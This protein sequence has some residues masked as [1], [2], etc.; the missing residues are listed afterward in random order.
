M[1]P[2]SCPWVS[3][4]TCWRWGE[5]VLRIP[6]WVWTG[7]QDIWR[8]MDC[9]TIRTFLNT[10]CR[11]PPSGLSA[12]SYLWKASPPSR[13]SFLSKRLPSPAQ[14]ALRGRVTH[15]SLR[16]PWSQRDPGHPS[17]PD[18][19]LC[20]VTTYISAAGVNWLDSLVCELL[21]DR[22]PGLHLLF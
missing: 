7:K 19:I 16:L 12:C 13:S 4:A 15:V 3:R 14:R 20:V 18:L 10:L 21:E 8:P 9:R 1:H 17:V 6:A 2:Y 22:G 5:S 11:V